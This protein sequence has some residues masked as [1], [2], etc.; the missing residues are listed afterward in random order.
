M[1]LVQ[2]GIAQA[3][4]G[5][6]ASQ[7]HLTFRRSVVTQAQ[8]AL[9]VSEQKAANV[10]EQAPNYVT[11]SAEGKAKSGPLASEAGQ[12]SAEN[13]ANTPDD[14]E[15]A[16]RA[17][18]QGGK[19][20]QVS[21]DATTTDD[22]I[23]QA[24]TASDTLV[25]DAARATQVNTETRGKVDTIQQTLGQTDQR[26][27]QMQ[28]QNAEAR[29]QLDGMMDQPTAMTAQAGE[30]DAEGQA[31]IQASVDM[32]TDLQQTQRSYT[33]GMQTVPGVE[34]PAEGAAPSGP[35]TVVGAAPVWVAL[36]DVQ[37]GHPGPGTTA[38][39][40]PDRP[41]CPARRVTSP[42]PPQGDNDETHFPSAA[43]RPREPP[44]HTVHLTATL[45]GY[46]V[47]VA[48]FMPECVLHTGTHWLV[49]FYDK[50]VDLPQDTHDVI[51]LFI[52]DGMRYLLA[53]D[54][55]SAPADSQFSREEEFD[56]RSHRIIHE[57]A[58]RQR[59]AFE[60]A[61]QVERQA[62]QHFHVEGFAN[63]DLD[64][65]NHAF[66]ERHDPHR[67]QENQLLAEG[68]GDLAQEI[69]ALNESGSLIALLSCAYAGRWGAVEGLG[70]DQRGI[71]VFGRFPRSPGNAHKRTRGRGP[72]PAKW[73][74][75]G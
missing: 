34:M 39:P 25:Q 22:A 45:Y 5:V 40:A 62:G 53:Q 13:R 68:S 29:A 9:T 50:D 35:D 47:I 7:D 8:Q 51:C 33:D 15:A 36:C 24:Q 17:Q 64:Q 61:G 56:L 14:E 72:R 32:E 20:N 3:E 70:L 65:F 38:G 71:D 12:M 46:I 42:L 44:W 30:L 57:H 16:A 74:V 10:A 52:G 27:N 37:V 75:G 41:N 69:G 11:K 21:S 59:A 67:I 43:S 73:I 58:A 2:Q 48:S 23:T 55:Q 31:L 60:D 4:G 66:D 19:I 18:E 26:L 49:C 1:G 63:F 28:G 54:M 6:H